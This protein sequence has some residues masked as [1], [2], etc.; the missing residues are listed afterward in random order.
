MSL[1][2]CFCR[3]KQMTF[4]TFIL[5]PVA[6]PTEWAREINWYVLCIWVFV[7]PP[8]GLLA[9]KPHNSIAE[10]KNTYKEIKNKSI[11]LAWVVSTLRLFSV[12]VQHP[13]HDNDRDGFFFAT[14]KT[15]CVI[16]AKKDIHHLR[17]QTSPLSITKPTRQHWNGS[18]VYLS[19]AI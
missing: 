9:K 6:K 14:N 11:P 15:K 8:C 2:N 16:P 12:Y 5:S 19:P 1:R 13:P 7:F 10:K 18:T 3:W 17:P 4:V